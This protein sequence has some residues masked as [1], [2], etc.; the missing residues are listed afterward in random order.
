MARNRFVWPPANRFDLDTGPNLVPCRLLAAGCKE[1]HALGPGCCFSGYVSMFQS[2]SGWLGEMSGQLRDVDLGS[3]GLA[4]SVPI[5]SGTADISLQ[6]VR[7]AQGRIEEMSGCV[8]TGRDG[9]VLATLAAN[10]AAQQNGW[11]ARLLPAADG[12]I[13]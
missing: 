5:N 11:L 4:G 3:A 13:K 10:R 12:A 6:K 2:P 8:V 9:R 7:F 1:L